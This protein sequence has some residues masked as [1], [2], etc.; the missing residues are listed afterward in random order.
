MKTFEDYKAEARDLREQLRDILNTLDNLSGHAQTLADCLADLHTD[1]DE[2][3]TTAL[4]LVNHVGVIKPKNRAKIGAKHF[5]LLAVLNEY[6]PM[7][8]SHIARLVG[9]SE[10]SV[11]LYAC[12]IRKNHLGDLVSKKG[13]YTLRAMGDGVADSQDFKLV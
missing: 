7:H 10:K 2:A 4:D 11:D 6:G 12:N 5:R 1:V 3:D 13:V 9:L 8:R